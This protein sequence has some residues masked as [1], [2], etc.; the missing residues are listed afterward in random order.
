MHSLY[1]EESTWLHHIPAGWKLGSLAL[2]GTGLFWLTDWRPLLVCGLVC[3]LLLYSLG[4]AGRGHGRLWRSLFIAGTLITAF[5][6]Y[7]QQAELGVA[8]ALRLWCSASLGI[9]LTLTTR[10][11]DLLAVLERLL[12][13]LQRWGVRPERLALHLALMLRFTEH[14]FLQ[15]KRLDDAYRARSGRSGGWRLLAPMTIQ[16]L[17]TARRVADALYTRLGP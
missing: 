9:M 6:A 2:L 1:S 17:Q 11:S 3:A 13:P 14:F 16:M 5:H 8:T 4:R 12:M 15:W 7:F 10:Y